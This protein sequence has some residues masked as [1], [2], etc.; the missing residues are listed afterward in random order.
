MT[1]HAHRLKPPLSKWIFFWSTLMVFCFNR[2]PKITEFLA[3]GC[4]S[5]QCT[6]EKIVTQFFLAFS[7][8]TEYFRNLHL[9]MRGQLQ[10]VVSQCARRAHDDR[11]PSNQGRVLGF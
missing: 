6:K 2:N 11:T 8:Q 5:K 3:L 4:S 1:V 9:N 10:K 7:G